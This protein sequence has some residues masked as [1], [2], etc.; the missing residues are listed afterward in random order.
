VKSSDGFQATYAL[1]G[2]VTQGRGT[3]A[4]ATGVQVRVLAAKEGMKVIGLKVG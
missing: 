1:D 4:L 2:T 3:G